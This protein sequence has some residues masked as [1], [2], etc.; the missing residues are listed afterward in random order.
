MPSGFGMGS[1]PLVRIAL[2]LIP[3]T[4]LLASFAGFGLWGGGG[5]RG[6]WDGGAGAV[7]EEIDDAAG[8]RLPAGQAGGVE[9]ADDGAEEVVGVEVGAEI[10]GFDGSPDKG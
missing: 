10:T 4:A 6:G 2:Y 8:A 7:E 1:L 9:K 3:A 5:W